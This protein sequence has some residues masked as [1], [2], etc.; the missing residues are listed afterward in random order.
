MNYN[1]SFT[2]EEFLQLPIYPHARGVPANTDF[3]LGEEVEMERNG[4]SGKFTA[5]KMA[6]QKDALLSVLEEVTKANVDALKQDP[7]FYSNVIKVKYWR[8]WKDGNVSERGGHITMASIVDS[9]KPK[10]TLDLSNLVPE[11]DGVITVV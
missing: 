8:K 3:L 6:G 7:A 11:T 5:G 10:G 2:K 4:Q 1:K 9:I